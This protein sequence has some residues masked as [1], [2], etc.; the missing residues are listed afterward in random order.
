MG[1][2]SVAINISDGNGG[3]THRVVAQVD[4][5]ATH[6]VLPASFLHE[7]GIQ[8]KGGPEK[9]RLADDSIVEWPMG[10]ARLQVEGRDAISPVV[11]AE[12]EMYLLGATSLQVLNLIPDTSNERLIPTPILRI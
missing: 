11:F 12:A 9:F 2:F 7:V 6:T 8:P 3:P 4:T 1:A 5:G 10:Q